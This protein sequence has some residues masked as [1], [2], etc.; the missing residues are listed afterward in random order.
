MA[1]EKNKQKDWSRE[2]FVS[3][4]RKWASSCEIEISMQVNETTPACN[5]YLY[6]FNCISCPSKTCGVRGIASYKAE[7][8]RVRSTSEDLHGDRSR[9]HGNGGLTLRCKAL[10]RNYLKAHQPFRLQLL[11]EHLQEKLGGRLLPDEKLVQNFLCNERKKIAQDPD[12][13]NPRAASKTAWTI[14][15]F[16]VFRA[17]SQTMLGI[18]D[19]AQLTVLDWSFEADFYYV[20]TVPRLVTTVME[21]L[22]TGTV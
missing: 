11:M 5:R 16:E 6:R 18:R 3:E 9:R 19:D 17:R 20:F 13:E 22:A 12:Q 14:P 7:T 2:K 21:K 8:F 10:V 4:V 15:D 1:V